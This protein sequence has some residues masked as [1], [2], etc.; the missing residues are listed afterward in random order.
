[1][2]WTAVAFVLCAFL[3]GGFVFRRRRQ[4][5][6][7][8]EDCPYC[9]RT[10]IPAGTH[11]VKALLM[12]GK[13]IAIEDSKPEVYCQFCGVSSEREHTHEGAKP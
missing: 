6:K 8:R 2:T 1:M 3:L 13:I 4:K 9:H 7:P 10:A 12:D 5:Q 11:T